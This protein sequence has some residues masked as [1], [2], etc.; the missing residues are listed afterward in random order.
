MSPLMKRHPIAVW[1]HGHTHTNT[2]FLAEGG[3]RVISNQRG[4]PS[5]SR[6][7]PDGT[8]A[9]SGFRHDLLIEV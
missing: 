6:R 3:C 7:A 2:D 9:E 4:Y 8:A 5:E 1:A